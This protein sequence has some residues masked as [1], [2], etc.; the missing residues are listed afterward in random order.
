MLANVVHLLIVIRLLDF[1]K[2]Y[3]WHRILSFS[4]SFHSLTHRLHGRQT[5]RHPTV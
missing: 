1:Q 2:P 3:L 4:T 5:P